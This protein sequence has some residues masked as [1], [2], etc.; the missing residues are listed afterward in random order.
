VKYRQIGMRG[1]IVLML[2]L[3]FGG[4]ILTGPL[5]WLFQIALS[6]KDLL[7]FA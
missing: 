7:V 2:L 1:M 5:N 6:I 4:P 3:W